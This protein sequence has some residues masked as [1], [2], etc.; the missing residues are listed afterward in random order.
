MKTSTT[1]SQ[2][3]WNDALRKV[4][5]LSRSF[6]D[7]LN[8]GLENNFISSADIIHASDIYKDPNKEWD[9]EEIKEIISSRGLRNIMEIIQNKYDL[10]DIVDKL[11]TDDIL[12][13]ID[14][15]KLLDALDNTWTLDRH[16]DEVREEY[17]RD[18]LNDLKDEIRGEEQEKVNELHDAHPDELRQFFCNL[19]GITY[20]DEDGLFQGFRNLFDKL[21]KSNYKDKR[22]LKWLLTKE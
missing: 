15:D 2:Q 1:W 7:I 21:E 14:D 8:F 20:Y 11:D 13:E 3:D 4:W 6:E 5:K 10:S 17:E 22:E 12:E 9:D 18:V 16:D 19:F